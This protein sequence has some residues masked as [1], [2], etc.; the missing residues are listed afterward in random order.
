MTHVRRTG[1]SHFPAIEKHEI[2]SI[3]EGSL[4]IR[5]H[6]KF[7]RR[8]GNVSQRGPPGAERN[9]RYPSLSGL[10]C[11]LGVECVTTLRGLAQYRS[12]AWT[13]AP[14]TKRSRRRTRIR[15]QQ[16]L[17]DTGI[18]RSTTTSR[19]ENAPF[20][21]D[22]RTVIALP[23][24]DLIPECPVVLSCRKLIA[25]VV[26]DVELHGQLESELILRS[27]P[28]QVLEVPC[29]HVDGRLEPVSHQVAEKVQS[30]EQCALAAR[31]RPHENVEPVQGNVHV[32][33]AAVVKGLESANHERQST[34]TRCDDGQRRRHHGPGPDSACPPVRRTA[35][36]LPLTGA[37][38]AGS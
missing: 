12:R 24:G 38:A 9:V 4:H 20:G 29:S 25:N 18:L 37:F 2:D 1:T 22:A 23:D 36:N 14:C 5:R 13:S 32:T 15:K 27:V 17:P 6:W 21:F 16:L 35:P 33:Q 19:H 8:F 26:W 31:V 10:V 28:D 7:F 3:F 11:G 30:V 34:M